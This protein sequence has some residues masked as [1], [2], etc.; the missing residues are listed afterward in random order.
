MNIP[1]SNQSCFECAPGT[2]SNEQGQAGCTSCGSQFEFVNS[3]GAD[4]CQTCPANA[5]A[6]AL[7]DG[8][9]NWTTCVC[10]VNFYAIPYFDTALLETLDP[11]TFLVFQNAPLL[12]FNPNEVLQFWY[13][14][15]PTSIL[16][17]YPHISASL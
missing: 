15:M 17:V 14:T 9:N 3:A 1:A 16:H 2:Y 6:P 11:N 10:V 4:R 8:N 12:A 5:K 7:A 13:V